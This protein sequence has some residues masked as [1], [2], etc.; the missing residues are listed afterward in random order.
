MTVLV[1][2]LAWLAP[3]VEPGQAATYLYSTPPKHCDLAVGEEALV[4]VVLDTRGEIVRQARV[5]LVIPPGGVVE[6]VEATAEIGSYL[7]EEKYEP[8]PDG[9]MWIRLTWRPDDP[10]PVDSVSVLTLRVR[11]IKP[12]EAHVMSR[13]TEVQGEDGTVLPKQA[14]NATKIRVHKEYP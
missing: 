2:V 3:V 6:A 5:I 9:S 8:R 10:A 1:T 12:G 11:A 14:T 4:G 7:A 13:F